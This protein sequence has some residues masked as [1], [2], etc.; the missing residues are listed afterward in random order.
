MAESVEAGGMHVEPVV[1]EGQLV[2]LEP[3]TS[4]HLP[5]LEKIAFAPEL[6]EWTNSR[7]T[8]HADLLRY[9]KTVLDQ[10]AAGTAMPWVTSCRADGRVIGS[11]RFMD[12]IPEHRTL[13]LGGTWVH[14]D[15]QRTG[16][17]VEAKYL[18]LT[19]AFEVMGVNR[20]AL[21]THHGNLKS[22]NAMRAMGATQEGVFRN[23]MIMHD[24]RLR[25]SVWFS[26]IRDEW[27][28]VK[29]GMERRMRRD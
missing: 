16:I 10:A 18:Q 4:A 17:N 28:E 15:Y 25:H 8:T 9:V 7:V 29:A 2:R 24:G 21:K 19:H 26:V 27:P 6:W 20:V 1:L 11:T 5:H 13:E 14:P 23:H 12:I 22:Q 3:M